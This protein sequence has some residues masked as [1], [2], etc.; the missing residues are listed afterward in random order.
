MEMLTWGLSFGV[1]VC[2][3]VVVH[4]AG[5]YLAA[6]AFGI[7]APVF[8]IGIGPP[9]LRLFH[10]RG[11]DFVVSGLPIG[12]YVKLAGADPFGEEDPDTFVDPSQDFMRRPVWQRFIVML[13]GP[14]MNLVL[15][16]VLLTAVFMT[17]EPQADNSVG[18]VIPDTPAA[19]AGIRPGDRVVSV[20]GQPV[21]VWND[22]LR[23]LDDKVGQP[24]VLGLERGAA[25][26]DVTLPADA[27]RLDMDGLTDTEALGVFSSRR[28]PR[29]GVSDIDSPAW[30][31]GLRPGDGIVAVDGQPVDSWEEMIAALTPDREHLVKRARAVEGGLEHSEVTLKPTGWVAPRPERDPNPWGLVHASVFVGTVLEGSAA[32]EAGFQVGDRILEMDGQTIDSWTKVLALGW[33]TTDGVTEQNAVAREITVVLHRA[34][35]TITLHLVPKVQREFFNGVVRYRPIM[36]VRQYSQT[37]VNGPQIKKFYPIT[38]AVGRAVEETNLVFGKTFGV[39]EGLLLGQVKVSEGLGGPVAIFQVAGDSAKEG[40]F[41]FVR[42]MAMISVSL[43][44]VNLLPVPVLDGGQITVYGIEAIRGRPLPL[45]IRE[46]IQM[47]G[48]LVLTAVFLMVTVLDVQRLFQG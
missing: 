42:M 31:A 7:G 11:T 19:R 35:Q 32:A 44:I 2:V 30:I 15:P 27:V 46:R 39:L 33:A 13:A 23:E 1:M 5:H 17:G 26:L 18:T 3:L 8:S 24:F 38:Q 43:G 9:L 41:A 48:F 14:L 34:G 4:E 6:K 29:I 45:R 10:W 40:V 12:G 37:Y 28:S 47:A 20:D 22:L 16:Y 21:E 36:G 25:H